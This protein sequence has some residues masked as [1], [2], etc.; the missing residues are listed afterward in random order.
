MRTISVH[1]SRDYTVSVGPGL[2]G[3]VGETLRPLTKASRAALVC[4]DRVW[5]LYGAVTAASLEAAGF[6]VCVK[7]IPHGE[8]HKT[9][10]TYGELLNFFLENELTRSDLVV[11]LGG[12]VTG[13]LAG[14]AAATYQRGVGF[15]Q[16]PTTLLAAV[17]S[18]V[19]G[20]T[21]IDLPGGKNQAGAFYQPLAVLCDTDALS[22]L[23]ETEYRCGCAEVIKYGVLFD[24]RF[25]DSLRSVPVSAQY[26]DV[27]AACVAFKRDAVEADEFDR[28]ERRLLN[29]GHSFGHAVE[30]C[31]SFTVRHG[32]AVAIGMAMIVRAAAERG[33]CTGEC[34][35]AVVSLLRA[36]GL[37]TE[38]D[39]P[40]AGL[41][42]ALKKDK[43]RGGDTLS[44]IVPRAV[45]R[46]E[47][48]PV[49]LDEAEAWLR[50]GGAL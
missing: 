11:A 7:V 5:P 42:A 18:S 27:I 49:A 39:I 15:V 3:R 29:L 1:A 36:Y 2:L 37:P 19:G 25:F 13:D 8:E 6:A 30:S 12:G 35:D 43:K 24:R 16:L 14:F 4:G 41:L 40:A 23:D 50:D 45:G 34:R 47:I 26:E 33:F 48:V 20:K 44:L 38:T 17:D 28:G 46:C 21:A 9:L 31:S 22:T 32:E 10:A